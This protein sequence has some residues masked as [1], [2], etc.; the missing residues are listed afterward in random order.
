MAGVDGSGAGPDGYSDPVILT[1]AAESAV[2]LLPPGSRL[3]FSGE[4]V[5]TSIAGTVSILG[6]CVAQ[7]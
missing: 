6:F 4:L 2:V 5:V 1:R 3:V 7:G